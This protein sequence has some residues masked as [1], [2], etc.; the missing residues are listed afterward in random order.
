MEHPL[1]EFTWRF[2]GVLAL[3]FANGFFVAA[4]FAIVTVRK[5][6]I[7]QLIEEGNRRARVVRRAASDPASYIAA[8]QLGITMTS[9]ALGWVGE[10]AIASFI[11][12]GIDFLPSHIA[13]P[14]AHSIAVVIAF[15]IVTALHITL[16]ELAPKTIAL[17]SAERTALLV[18]GPTELFRKIF[19]PFIRLLNGM[20]R[21]VVRLLGFR[22]SGGH[23]LV[24]S[25]EELK[26]LVTA[27][28]EAGVLEEEEEQMLHRV[29]D[30]ADVTAGQVMVPRTELVTVEASV[31]GDELMKVVGAAGYSVIPVYRTNLD[32]LVGM[33][34]AID[35][36]K[37]IAAGRR[38]VSAG[39]IARETLTVPETMG[40]DDLLASLRQRA[41]RE[42]IVIDEYGGTA[43]LVTF[44]WLMERIVGADG[45]TTMHADGSVD[46]DGLTL[47][48]DVNEQFALHIDES[49]Y[50]TLGGYVMGRIGRRA[51]L[52]DTID[53][54]GRRMR[55]AGLDGLRVARVWISAPAQPGSEAPARGA[56]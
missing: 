19:W 38:N 15:A 8:T 9:L 48:T 12:P 28:Q 56:Q 10:P 51:R 14:T 7:D 17:E 46:L 44:E 22:G 26:M 52:G 2:A 54:E 41:V 45:R 47:V 49:T 6:R 43:G 36:V 37:E 4:E 24:H 20:G 16:G 18:V 53:V 33:L 55:V 35:L 13:E 1:A 39:A 42:A 21:A 31:S 40:A 29:F 23:G 32:N 27:S 34:H 3:V 11:R 25:E 50:T 30:F 5:T